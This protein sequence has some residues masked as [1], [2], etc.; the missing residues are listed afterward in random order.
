MKVGTGRKVV[1]GIMILLLMGAVAWSGGQG[2]GVAKGEYTF[3]FWTFQQFHIAL[4]EDGA[5]R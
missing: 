5:K 1:L 2:E 3:T 4:L